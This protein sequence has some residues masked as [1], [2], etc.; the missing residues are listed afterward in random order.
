M[1]RNNR[2]LVVDD[3]RAIHDDFA[4][5]LATSPIN[6]ALESAEALLFDQQPAQRTTFELTSAYQG[7]EAVAKV[8]AAFDAGTPFAVAF[9]DIRMPPGIDGIETASRIWQCDPDL[10]VVMCS[11]FSDYAWSDMAANLGRAD[12]WVMLRKPF[13]NIEVMQLATALAEKWALQQIARAERKDLE[14]RVAERTRELQTALSRLE[15]ETAQRLQHEEQRR[16]IERKMEESQRWE[17][18]G[19]LAGGIAH[20]FNNVLTGVLAN[21]SV[22]RLEPT[23]SP[24]LDAHLQRIEHSAR[25][26]AE[27]CELMLAYAGKSR[28][29]RSEIELNQLVTDTWQL[30]RASVPRDVDF[31]MELTPGVG[32]VEADLVRLRQVLMNLVINGAEALGASPR[33]LIVSTGRT[34][35]D[36]AALSS[37]TAANES[38]PGDFV[39]IE[40][41]DT[42]SG[43]P[44]EAIRRIFE[45]FYT[46]KF[47]GRGLGL[48]AVQG[49]VRSHGGALTVESTPGLG[50]VFRVYLPVAAAHAAAT[51]QPVT[52]PAVPARVVKARATL[53]VVDDEESVRNVAAAALRH[54]GYDVETAA[55]GRHA[56]ATV[57]NRASA[58]DGIVL[59]LTMPHMNGFETLA[60]IR[61]LHARIPAVLMSGYI[62]E[63]IPPELAPVIPLSKP[64]EVDS[65]YRAVDSMLG[66]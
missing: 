59:D 56:L 16:A 45:P 30:L 62:N 57:K 49:I 12:R 20:D 31:Q 40:V 29:E 66:V 5:I 34:R 19:V 13:D 38:K 27:L 7:E 33:R 24:E 53:L 14:N 17:S 44:Q 10:L 18:I 23:L 15:A 47:E 2:I 51:S 42:G 58:F 3:N 65:L 4:K 54:R 64:F 61:S 11:A 37:M 8:K 6:A 21:A 55:D 32:H 63:S 25:R 39:W 60:A 28:L 52:A 43:M 46:T 1:T 26:A 50:S 35:L 9:V 22:A 41:R 36:A 48:C